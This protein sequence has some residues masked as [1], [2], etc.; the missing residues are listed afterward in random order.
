MGTWGYKLS[1]N[2]TS[3]DVIETFFEKYNAGMEPEAIKAS[4]LQQFSF[5]VNDY[6]DSDNVFFPL[7]NCLWEVCALDDDLFD[8]TRK[9][10]GS[11]EHFKVLKGLGA[12]DEFLKK[13]K[14]ILEKYLAKIAV[15]REKPKAR[16]KPPVRV[17]SQYHNGSCMVFQYPN[18]DYGGVVAIKVDFYNTTGSIA[19]AL[20]NIRKDIKPIFSDFENAMLTKFSW[21]WVYGQSER[22]AAIKI[23]DKLYAGRINTHGLYYSNKQER[24]ALFEGLDRQFQVVGAFPTFTQILLAG[25]G[26]K[27]NDCLKTYDYYYKLIDTVTV[28]HTLKE[29]SEKLS[30]IQEKN[31]GTSY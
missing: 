10:I 18:G 31:D 24:E 1:E 25:T 6:E 8:L 4:I 20:T 3:R 16:K 17:E 9:R 13:R 26:D 30:N 14:Q 2:D 12:N 11:G 15:P 27:I 29:L 19:L 7:A 22:C 23:D 5:S 28:N 21:E